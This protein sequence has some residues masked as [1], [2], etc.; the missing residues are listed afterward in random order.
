MKS[1]SFLFLL[2]AGSTSAFMGTA[3]LNT[4]SYA[5]S[6]LFQKDAVS[7]RNVQ[8]AKLR[9]TMVSPGNEDISIQQPDR[10][11]R[12]C[13]EISNFCLTICIALFYID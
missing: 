9:P 3:H 7:R 13:V 6:G 11:H 4:V 5:K 8:N 10:L 12:R 2:F 1:T